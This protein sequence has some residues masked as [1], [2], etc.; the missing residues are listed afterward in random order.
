[1]E[2]LGEIIIPSMADFEFMKNA[3]EK[4]DGWRLAYTKKNVKIWSRSNEL[5]KYSVYRT[6]IDCDVSADVMYD[7]QQDDTYKYTKL[8]IKPNLLIFPMGF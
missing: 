6:R 8:L 7:V 5:S 4:D 3:C 2:R 1:M